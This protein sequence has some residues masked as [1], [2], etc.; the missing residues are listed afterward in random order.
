MHVSCSES[1][2]TSELGQLISILNLLLCNISTFYSV[3]LESHTS[4][5]ISGYIPLENICLE[6]GE[7]IFDCSL[8]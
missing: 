6:Y 2:P 3:S 4:K 5:K 7:L 1:F 8:F